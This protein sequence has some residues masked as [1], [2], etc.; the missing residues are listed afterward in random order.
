MFVRIRRLR[1]AGRRI[2]EHEADR[3]EHEAVGDLRSSAGRFELHRQ[4]ENTGPADVLYDAHVVV[5][6]PGVGGML[7]RGYEEHRGSGVLQEWEVTPLEHVIGPD[8]LNRW[9]WSP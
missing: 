7:L 1:H 6:H 9:N 3:P 8:G 4:L 5:V 2:P